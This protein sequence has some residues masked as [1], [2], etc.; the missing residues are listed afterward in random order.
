MKRKKND[1]RA[2]LK[3]SGFK[4]KEGKPVYI[5]K[6]THDKIAMLVRWLG[7]GEVTIADF[8]ENV[9]IEFLRNYRDELN[10]MLNTIPEEP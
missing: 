9:V 1:Y 6:D 5:S 3:K 8:T 2:F 10:P 7:N 4:A